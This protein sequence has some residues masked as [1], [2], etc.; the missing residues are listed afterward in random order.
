MDRERPS[1]RKY[2]Y[3]QCLVVAAIFLNSF[4]FY[5]VFIIFRV[6]LGWKGVSW[7]DFAFNYLVFCVL[8]CYFWFCTLRC[9]LLSYCVTLYV[10]FIPKII[11]GHELRRVIH[12]NMVQRTI[13]IFVV[14]TLL[15][16][17]WVCARFCVCVCVC[18]QVYL[19]LLLW[20]LQLLLLV[21]WVYADVPCS[22]VL[23][24]FISILCSAFC[25]CCCRLFAEMMIISFG[26]FTLSNVFNVTKMRYIYV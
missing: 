14:C 23:F 4:N 12:F 10:H 5:I 8:F 26:F 1:K 17:V 13:N 25:Y 20:L 21:G 6:F 16:C 3:L 22:I 19:F 7:C 2:I 18:A 15:L 11:I 24:I 9:S